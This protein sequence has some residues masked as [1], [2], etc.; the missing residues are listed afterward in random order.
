MPSLASTFVKWK[1]RPWTRQSD[2][3][4]ANFKVLDSDLKALTLQI[5]FFTVVKLSTGHHLFQIRQDQILQNFSN[6]QYL[7][8][9]LWSGA[10]IRV[11]FQVC[12]TSF[13]HLRGSDHLIRQ[14]ATAVHVSRG[15]L[16]EKLLSGEASLY[17][18]L[19]TK[20]GALFMAAVP[21]L[22]VQWTVVSAAWIVHSGPSS[23]CSFCRLLLAAGLGHESF[24]PNKMI[25]PQC[26]TYPKSRVVRE[27]AW[28]GEIKVEGSVGWWVVF[29][30][31]LAV[32]N[33][34]V[35]SDDSCWL[36]VF[37]LTSLFLTTKMLEQVVRHRC[38]VDVINV[39]SALMSV[40]LIVAASHADTTFALAA[41]KVSLI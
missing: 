37:F 7:L 11:L 35:I 18:W 13:L 16:G 21:I 31:C 26:D 17:L 40:C 10:M 24:I 36:A 19:C 1:F 3:F 9:L 22:L 28:G 29:R 20:R 6:P 8:E 2:A 38:G 25:P 33:E 14:K 5:H 4:R 32:H 12:W 34:R 30:S 15:K 23:T 41:H 39:F 27:G